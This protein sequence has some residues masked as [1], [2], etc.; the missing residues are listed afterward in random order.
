MVSKELKE[1]IE[2]FKVA[3]GKWSTQAG[4]LYQCC[5]ATDVFIEFVAARRKELLIELDIKRFEFDI[6]DCHG[7]YP[8]IYKDG[9]NESGTSRALWHC[10]VS[11]KNVLIDWT[12]RQYVEDAPFPLIIVKRHLD[13]KWRGGDYY[14]AVRKNYTRKRMVYWKNRLAKATA[15]G[16]RA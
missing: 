12:A 4:A 14:A 3:Y 11:T 9:V 8:T 1:L 16:A 13:I 5:D 2:A 6:K 15:A 7:L 10:I